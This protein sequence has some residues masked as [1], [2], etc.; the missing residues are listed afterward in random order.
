MNEQEAYVLAA[1][2]WMGACLNDAG[3]ANIPTHAL[4]GATATPTPSDASPSSPD[5][6]G[7]KGGLSR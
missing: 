2:D 4:A 1:F 3:A 6:T 7:S 5:N